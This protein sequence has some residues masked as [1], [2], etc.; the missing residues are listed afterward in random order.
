MLKE[1]V[2]EYVQIGY[3]VKIID[4]EGLSIDVLIPLERFSDEEGECVEI[5][6]VNVK[7]FDDK[8]SEFCYAADADGGHMHIFE[9]VVAQISPEEVNEIESEYAE[10]EEQGYLLDQDE[11]DYDKDG[12]RKV[13]GRVA[14]IDNAHHAFNIE[15]NFWSQVATKKLFKQV[16]HYLVSIM[17]VDFI[18]LDINHS[19]VEMIKSN[20][21]LSLL[22]D[23]EKL[24]EVYGD[25][26]YKEIREE[27][28]EYLFE[29]GYMRAGIDSDCNYL[30]KKA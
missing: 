23:T 30:V 29:Y 20:P 22:A 7:V 12:K 16:E 26:D 9:D 3:Q 11:I 1:E 19:S 17:N 2:N 10:A 15:K 8:W 14:I 25:Y 24:L 13:W 28:E 21:S 27:V 6:S 5:G 4:Q 18:V